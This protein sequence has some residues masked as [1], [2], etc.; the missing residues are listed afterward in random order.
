M[1]IDYIISS[2]SSSNSFSI[3]IINLFVIV[4]SLYKLELTG[5]LPANISEAGGSAKR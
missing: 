5:D 3:I 2:T 4:H 1:G